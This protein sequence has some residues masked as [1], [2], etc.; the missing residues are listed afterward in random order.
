MSNLKFVALTVLE[1][2]T[3]D[4]QKFR[5]SRDPGSPFLKKDYHWKHARQINLTVCRSHIYSANY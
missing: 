1:L 3:F 2:I 5:G 4:N